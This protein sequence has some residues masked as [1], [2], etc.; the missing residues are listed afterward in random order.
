MPTVKE[1]KWNQDNDLDAVPVL[2]EEDKAEIDRRLSIMDKLLADQGKAKYKIEFLFGR[3]RSNRAPYSGAVSF[4]ESGTKFHGG[5]DTKLYMCPGATLGINDCQ[6]FIPDPSNGYGFCVCPKCQKVW[7][8][9][10]VGGEVF[11]KLPTSKWALIAL[12]FFVA[13]EH[14]ADI[15]VKSLERT[16]DL[17]KATELEKERNRGGEVLLAARLARTP[18]IYP[19]RNILVDTANGAD[20]LGRFYAFL[21]S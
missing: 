20:I 7:K 3:D 8:D 6:G 18:F 12:K 9:E 21:S 4:W 14:N 13:L 17:R 10:Q 1:V 19:L 2:S 15:Y 16:M 5:G 11:Y